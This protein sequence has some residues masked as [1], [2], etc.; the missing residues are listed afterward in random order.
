MALRMTDLDRFLQAQAF[1]YDAALL[2]IKRGKKQGHWMWFIFPQIQGLGMSDV[3]NTFALNSITEAKAYLDHP[4]LGIRL[5]ECV[6]AL[7]AQ[8][9]ANAL[10]IFSR[11]DALKLRS[12]LTLFENVATDNQKFTQALE[13]LCRGNRDK[14]TLE[15]ISCNHS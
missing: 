15:L 3:A 8:P 11:T 12:C 14:Q 1:Y 4:I 10:E 7:L 13:K 2:E 5:V 6:E 9:C